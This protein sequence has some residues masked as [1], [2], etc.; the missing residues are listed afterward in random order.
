M[1][2]GRAKRRVRVR[3]RLYSGIGRHYYAHITEDSNPIWCTGRHD[4][5]EPGH[6]HEAW[7]DAG[8]NGLDFTQK[9]DAECWAQKWIREIITQHFP[10][11]THL[12][13]SENNGKPLRDRWFYR[14]GD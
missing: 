2:P 7:D 1:F 5:T 9:F 14:E 10:S 4:F 11:K 12:V 8:K 3:I 6:W 13:V